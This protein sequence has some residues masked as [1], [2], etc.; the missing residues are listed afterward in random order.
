MMSWARIPCAWRS[1]RR[2]MPRPNTSR[3]SRQL[4]QRR[5]PSREPVA[6]WMPVPRPRGAAM[7]SL[8]AAMASSS[9][10]PLPSP[11][12]PT[13]TAWRRLRQRG[14]PW[15]RRR[16][17]VQRWRTRP[18]RTGPPPP[19][20]QRRGS[21]P[22]HACCSAS[23]ITSRAGRPAAS[24]RPFSLKRTALCAKQTGARWPSRRFRSE[25]PSTPSQWKHRRRR[26]LALPRGRLTM[27]LAMVP[28]WWWT[29]G[30]VLSR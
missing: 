30:T 18:V 11:M 29:S 9:P 8:P 16:R 15:Y 26:L 27:P 3:R 5:P 25:P 24:R 4:G 10:A 28:P 20:L 22:Q 7:R 12:A 13:G 19:P 23:W 6:L 17:S 2:R 14:Q 21:W 1:S